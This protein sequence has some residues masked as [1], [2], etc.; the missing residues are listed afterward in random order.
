MWMI[1]LA[2]ADPVADPEPPSDL[3]ERAASRLRSRIADHSVQ[4]TGRNRITLL[5][6]DGYEQELFLDTLAAACASQPASCD[7]ELT[8]WIDRT[9]RRS[10]ARGDPLKL[11]RLRPMVFNEQQAREL[12]L[13]SE[14]LAG[15]L[16]V[17]LV[18]D[19]DR[20]SR[21][22][23]VEGLAPL[24]VSLDE[25]R[26]TAWMLFREDPEPARAADRLLLDDWEDGVVVRAV[27][28][29]TLLVGTAD[30][31]AAQEPRRTDLSKVTLKR[32]AMKW[33]PLR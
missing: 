12:Q 19:T 25:A 9:G 13:E 15:D 18:Q 29:A 10:Q 33:R 21:V 27:D 22:V 4:V 2:C 17:V 23:D 6:P 32:D 30:E 28:P 8:A 31:V 26:E 5:G 14:P 1:L 11:D 3:E 16:V 7:L 24:G 20:S